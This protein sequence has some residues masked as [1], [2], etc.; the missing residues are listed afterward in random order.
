VIVYSIPSIYDELVFYCPLGSQAL[1][2]SESDYENLPA[3][4]AAAAGL[5]YFLFFETGPD[6]LRESL[7]VGTLKYLT[8]KVPPGH[9]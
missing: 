6:S 7:G 1:F 9:Q 3:G 4:L 2:S 8:E 5:E